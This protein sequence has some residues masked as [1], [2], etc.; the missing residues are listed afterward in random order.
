MTETSAPEQLT[1]GA[2]IR[3]FSCFPCRQRK[4]RCDR[5]HPCSPCA[6]MGKEC[7]FVAPLRGK[8][9]GKRA[10]KEGLHA[11]LQRYEEL[12]KSYGVKIELTN[13]ADISDAESGSEQ[14]VAV[15]D[16]TEP[17]MK[18]SSEPFPNSRLVAKDGTSRYFDKC[19]WATRFHKS[20]LNFCSG[21]WSNLGDEVC[22][23]TL[24]QISF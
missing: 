13:D 12:L 9:R 18:A 16:H 4:V 22:S 6:R 11:K 23:S 3:S 19:V 21:I 5:R 14:A 2:D 20:P 15:T 1:L 10:P 24:F 8:R 17:R 7:S